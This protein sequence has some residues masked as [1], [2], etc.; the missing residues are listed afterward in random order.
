[1]MISVP[2]TLQG[3]DVSVIAAGYNVQETH[4]CFRTNSYNGWEKPKETR[5]SSMYPLVSSWFHQHLSVINHIWIGELSESVSPFLHTA[6]HLL[7]DSC[8]RLISP[9]VYI[10][11]R[12]TTGALSSHPF[13]CPVFAYMHNAWQHGIPKR[14]SNE[15]ALI[16][17]CTW[18]QRC[19][20]WYLRSNYGLVPKQQWW[21]EVCGM[22]KT[23][24]SSQCSQANRNMT[25]C[26]RHPVKAAALERI[27]EAF[28]M[29]DYHKGAAEN[30][31]HFFAT[32][33]CSTREN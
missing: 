24:L 23:L 13:P 2:W 8:V 3:F 33:T 25:G 5:V 28:I 15:R 27:N 26:E 21:G 11:E 6:A 16:L 22:C 10:F 31:H 29:I 12:E 30:F 14:G 17:V 7:N 1:M 20:S 32:F 4:W 18:R 9:V 19:P